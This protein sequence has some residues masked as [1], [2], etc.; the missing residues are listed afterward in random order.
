MPPSQQSWEFQRPK[1]SDPAHE[2]TRL[3]P[4]RD[5]RVR[6]SAW[7]GHEI[8][9]L[10]MYYPTHSAPELFRSKLADSED[11]NLVNL[12]PGESDKLPATLF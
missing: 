4:E 10:K 12:L 9:I 3:Q 7:L 6:F 11:F 1:L 2:G 8:V 5:G